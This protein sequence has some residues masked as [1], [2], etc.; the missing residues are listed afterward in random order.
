M[1]YPLSPYAYRDGKRDALIVPEW[2]KPIMGFAIAFPAS[3]RTI[4]VEYDVNLLYWKQEY[5]PAE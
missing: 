2:S 5:G 3:K 1:L 4:K